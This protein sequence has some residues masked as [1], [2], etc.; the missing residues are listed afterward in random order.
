LSLER[1]LR[2]LEGFGL[3]RLDAEVY[4]YLAKRGPQNGGAVAV[5]LKIRNRQ[6]HNILKTLQDRGVVSASS[7]HPVLFSAVGFEE[8]INLLVDADLEQTKAIK[9]IQ[10]ELLSE[11]RSM[12]NRDKT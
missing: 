4:V 5:A 12:I 8:A 1:V 10:E 6:L 9:N 3:S 11:W 7:R 2:T